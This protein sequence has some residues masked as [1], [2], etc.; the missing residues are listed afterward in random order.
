MIISECLF[1]FN[2]WSP[3][4][5]HSQKFGCDTS[6]SFVTQS[7][8]YIQYSPLFV[9]ACT[10]SR[11]NFFIKAIFRGGLDESE[12]P[13]WSRKYFL[14]TEF[15]FT[16][17]GRE[18]SWTTC[19]VK[20]CAVMRRGRII[21]PGLLLC[22]GRRPHKFFR[23]NLRNPAWLSPFHELFRML[24]IFLPCGRPSV[25]RIASLSCR[26]PPLGKVH[27]RTLPKIHLF[28]AS[29]K[30]PRQIFHSVRR[31]RWIRERQ[32]KKFFEKNF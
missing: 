32:V 22:W 31:L 16:F 27:P 14:P 13:Q 9:P 15:G 20:T 8:K 6:C 10:R 17:L 18:F 11:S 28:R 4:K 1:M 29:C 19:F 23:L 26:Q 30:N 21:A 7:G 24:L 3:L 2:V 5:I 12:I 25:V